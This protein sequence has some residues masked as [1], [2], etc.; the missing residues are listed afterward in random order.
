MADCSRISLY[1]A[2]PVATRWSISCTPVVTLVNCISKLDNMYN[3]QGW[4]QSEV[5]A[6][7]GHL[8]PRRS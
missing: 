7:E 2:W 1:E 6:P 4:R 8:D 3:I 5:L